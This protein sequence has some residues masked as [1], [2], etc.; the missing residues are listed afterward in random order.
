MEGKLTMGSPGVGGSLSAASDV[1]FNS[2]ADGQTIQRSGSYWV[3]ATLAGGGTGRL[4]EVEVASFS[5]ASYSAKF[6]NALA[7]VGAMNP[8]PALV[9][10]P[11]ATID[12]GSTP[13]LIP[14]GVSLV[15]GAAVQTEFGH[16]CPIY[17][18]ATGGTAV[19]QTS[20]RGTNESGTKGWSMSNIAFEGLT[21][22]SLFADNP[23]DSSGS[24][25]AYNSLHNVCADQFNHIYWGPMLGTTITGTTYYN[26]MTNTAW[27]IVGSDNTLWTDGGFF[28]MNAWSATTY[29]TK[30]ALPAMVR[31]GTL[32]KTTIGPMYITGSPTTVLQLNGGAGGI[33][34]DNLTIEGRPV[35]GS[36]PNYMWCAGELIR[37]TGGSAI[38][39]NKWYGYAMKDPSA[40]GRAS[41]GYI[42]I[43]GG[44][45]LIDGGCVQVYSDQASSPP[46]FVRITGGS[47]IVR[48]ITRGSNTTQKPVVL[49]TNAAYVDAD[50][51]VTVMVG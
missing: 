20:P 13:F 50:L 35:V 39:R 45:H 44:N 25:W 43:T 2:P 22:I 47:V 33:A 29:A 26:N 21:S 15:G 28:E 10:T 4:G 1:L 8:K 19:F 7:A 46:P 30:A 12:A 36:A 32:S 51:T 31:L 48:N 9:L 27:Y 40:T 16:N 24:I 42:H 49:T 37:L 34:L 38:L 14:A 18:R 17:A 23:M 5:G 11:G 6:R 41:E 3:N